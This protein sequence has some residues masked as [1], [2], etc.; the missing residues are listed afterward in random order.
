MA[1]E[2]KARGMGKVKGV[3]V[4]MEVWGVERDG[5]ETEQVFVCFWML[6]SKCVC[7]TSVSAAIDVR[8]CARL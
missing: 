2:F 3:V 7:A 4:V 6:P 1:E 8:M 5:T